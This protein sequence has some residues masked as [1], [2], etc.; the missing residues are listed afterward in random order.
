MAEAETQFLV[1]LFYFKIIVARDKSWE[2]DWTGGFSGSFS[3][4]V[5][6]FSFFVVKSESKRDWASVFHANPDELRITA[7]PSFS[8]HT[9]L[10]LGEESLSLSQL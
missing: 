2:C 3:V 1:G 8:D 9:A 4:L 7:N 10:L 6:L 5:F